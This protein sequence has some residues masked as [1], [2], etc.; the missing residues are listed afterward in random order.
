MARSCMVT[1]T[2]VTSTPR[3][4]PVMPPTTSTSTPPVRPVSLARRRSA[5]AVPNRYSRN[6]SRA[7]QCSLLKNRSNSGPTVCG[8]TT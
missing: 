3:I 5:C 2:L 4:R 1:K 7:P 8:A 6:T